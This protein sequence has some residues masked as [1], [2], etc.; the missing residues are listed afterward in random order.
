MPAGRQINTGCAQLLLLT[1]K[2][3][4]PV[5]RE[6]LYLP[7]PVGNNCY[8]SK[9]NTTDLSDIP[10]TTLPRTTKTEN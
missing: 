9:T 2:L 1:L 4:S 10:R 7:F 5:E 3:V 6:K 8:F